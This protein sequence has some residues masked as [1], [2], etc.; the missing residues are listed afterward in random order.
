MDWGGL[1]TVLVK[2]ISTMNWHG[3]CWVLVGGGID[4]VVVERYISGC[5]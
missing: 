5:G 3:F 1:C 4:D 2:A